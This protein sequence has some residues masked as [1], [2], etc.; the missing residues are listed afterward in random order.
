M[1]VYEFHCPRCN[2][3]LEFFARRA[4]AAV[5]ACPHCGGALS[6]EV[7]RFSTGPSGGRDDAEELGGSV[8]DDARAQR[9]VEALGDRLDAIGNDSDPRTAAKA[10]REFSEAS[11]LSFSPEV[12]DMVSRL[13]RGADPETI[14]A[15]LDQ[16]VGDGAEPFAPERGATAAAAPEAPHAP[17]AP[18]RDPILHDMPAEPLPPRRPSPWS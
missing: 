15:E 1:P 11:G 13:E 17:A 6:R 4:T 10:V 5:P 3:L 9:A 7:A 14:G 16:L 18:R 2:L 12:R 8:V